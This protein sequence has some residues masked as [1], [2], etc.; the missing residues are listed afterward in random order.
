M[1]LIQLLDDFLHVKS[2]FCCF[3]NPP[4]SKPHVLYSVTLWLLQLIVTLD[5]IS[6]KKLSVFCLSNIIVIITINIYLLILQKYKYR[7]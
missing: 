6:G 7:Q 1:L 2:L 3:L 4:H 5:Y